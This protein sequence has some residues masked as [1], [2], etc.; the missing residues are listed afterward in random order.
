MASWFEWIFSFF[1]WKTPARLQSH[2]Y[3]IT[4]HLGHTSHPTDICLQRSKD[5]DESSA[6]DYHFRSVRNSYQQGFSFHRQCMH[7]LSFARSFAFFSSNCRFYSSIT[8]PISILS[9]LRPIL[10]EPQPGVLSSTTPSPTRTSRSLP[11]LW[12]PI[13]HHTSPAPVSPPMSYRVRQASDHWMQG[14]SL[15]GTPPS[16][17]AE[18]TSDSMPQCEIFYS[19]V[20][21]LCLPSSRCRWQTGRRQTMQAT[22][23][24]LQGRS[25]CCR[26]TAIWLRPFGSS[27]SVQYFHKGNLRIAVWE[28][29]KFKFC[30]FASTRSCGDGHWHRYAWLYRVFQVEWFRANCW[31]R[32]SDWFLLFIFL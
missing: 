5:Q 6:L 32:T 21:L 1:F 28:S 3:K 4:F 22:N 11:L 27:S 25:G 20:H 18:K 14:K 16:T 7:A 10:S 24:W 30:S 12:R 17:S 26:D 8:H 31:D 19:P 2:R 13:L 15:L 29:K 9:F 23:N